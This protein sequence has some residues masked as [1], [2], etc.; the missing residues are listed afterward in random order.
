MARWRTSGFASCS[1]RHGRTSPSSIGQQVGIVRGGLEQDDASADLQHQPPLRWM[2]P[3]SGLCA[4]SLEQRSVAWIV[5]LPIA[6]LHR[7]PMSRCSLG[8]R[9]RCLRCPRQGSRIQEPSAPH[10]PVGWCVEK[11]SAGH[12][13]SRSIRTKP[14]LAKVWAYKPPDH[15]SM[16]RMLP[17]TRGALPNLTGARAI[18]VVGNDRAHAIFQPNECFRRV[19]RLG[20]EQYRT[21]PAPRRSSIRRK[22]R[23]RTRCSPHEAGRTS[24]APTKKTASDL[25]FRDR[26]RSA[27]GAP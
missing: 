9:S 16:A 2:K 5:A 8:H 11:R 27:V 26:W 18:L 6:P 14:L 15:A 10:R 24:A 4:G 20:P 1:N 22:S 13:T 17:S 19:E 12:P 3:D 21:V 25:R 7:R 23:E